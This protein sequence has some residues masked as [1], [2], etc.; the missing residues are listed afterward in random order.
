M[1]EDV[2]ETAA[3]AGLLVGRGADLLVGRQAAGH[4]QVAD[5]AVVHV[6]DV[7]GRRLLVR[8]RPERLVDRRVDVLLRRDHE[9][10][11]AA[12]RRGGDLAGDL[13]ERVG[14]RDRPRPRWRRRP[15]AS[16]GSGRSA[17]T[18]GAPPAG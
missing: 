2:A 12:G 1:D 17:R 16:G 3:G 15:A 14:R 7:P 11:R 18:A 13:V 6:G 8:H 9:A 5:A 4:Q 10:H